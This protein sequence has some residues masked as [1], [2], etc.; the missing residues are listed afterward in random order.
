MVLPWLRSMTTQRFN[1]LKFLVLINAV[2]PYEKAQLEK[3]A[4]HLASVVLTWRA[5]FAR[6]LYSADFLCRDRLILFCYLALITWVA[7]GAVRTLAITVLPIVFH[8]SDKALLAFAC[9]GLLILV[10]LYAPFTQNHQSGACLLSRATSTKSYLC[11]CIHDY[12]HCSCSF[13]KTNGD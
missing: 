2:S 13:R 8:I 3:K 10:C 12:R 6:L 9:P 1:D 5:C 4:M 7:Q 11:F